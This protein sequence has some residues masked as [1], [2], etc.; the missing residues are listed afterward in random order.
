MEDV[1][2]TQLLQSDKM[3]FALSVHAWVSDAASQIKRS[4]AH[5]A[6]FTETRVQT[7]DKH[8]LI[9]NAFKKKGYL[10]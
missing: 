10:T 5:I 6:V 7:M 2:V 4:G 1:L 9:V 3:S 8:N